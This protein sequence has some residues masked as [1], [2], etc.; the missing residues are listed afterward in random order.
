MKFKKLFGYIPR[1]IF[2][3][4]SS[5]IGFILIGSGGVANLATTI[6]GLGLIASALGVDGTFFPALKYL[7]GK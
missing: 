2:S 3:I 5:V 7:G 6:P 1:L 4:I